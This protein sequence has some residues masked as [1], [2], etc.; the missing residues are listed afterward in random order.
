VCIK[1]KKK[2]KT[3]QWFCCPDLISLSLF[4]MENL[5]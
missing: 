3:L 2:K 5:E 4:L 1:K